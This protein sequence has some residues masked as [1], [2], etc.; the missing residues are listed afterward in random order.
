MWHSYSKRSST[1][2]LFLL[3]GHLLLRNWK[4]IPLSEVTSGEATVS[5]ILGQIA[6]MPTLKIQV[7]R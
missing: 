4:P 1:Q 2:L 5:E 6:C 7:E 3:S